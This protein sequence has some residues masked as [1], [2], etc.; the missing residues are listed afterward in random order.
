[1][2]DTVKGT[3]S[4]TQNLFQD[5]VMQEAIK[6]KTEQFYKDQQKQLDAEK[7]FMDNVGKIDNDEE[8]KDSDD[9]DFGDDDDGIMEA[10]KEQRMKEMKAKFQELQENKIKGHGQ[11]I[12]ITE[13]EFL[14]TVTKS[15]FSVVHFY[16]NDFE[17]CKIVDKHLREI[18]YKHQETKFV[19]LNA[20]KCP[21]FI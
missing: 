5:M 21:F 8:K 15:K 3:Q 7:Q 4:L 10:I 2:T 12:E 9:S 16:H 14:P 20:E 1:M 6:D 17:R 18:A 13:E 19:Y 11:Y